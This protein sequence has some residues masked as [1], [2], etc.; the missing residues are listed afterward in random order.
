VDEMKSKQARKQRK[1]QYNAPEHVRSRAVASHLSESLSR[2]YR[3]RTARVIEGDTVKVIRGDES[4]KGV[5]GKVSKVN[6]K[7]GRLIIEGITMPKAD[8]TQTARSIHASNVIITRLDLSDTL[9]RGRL[10]RGE[11]AAQ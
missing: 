11:G 10:Q 7:T 8:G 5:E 1:A 3:R 9:R 4:V 2:E 6:T